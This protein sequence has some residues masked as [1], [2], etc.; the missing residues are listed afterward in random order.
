MGIT[1]PDKELYV[2]AHTDS[3][4]WLS[5]HG[6]PEEELT[7]AAR[8]HI[9]EL[10][11]D[12]L[13]T[14]R[15]VPLPKETRDALVD[16]FCAN[17]KMREY[18]KTCA[19]NEDCLVRVYLGGRKPKPKAYAGGGKFFGLRNFQLNLD[20]MVCLEDPHNGQG[21]LDL[22]DVLEL[23]KQMGITLAVMHWD[24][25]AHTDAIDV[26][27]VLG[28][29]RERVEATD[30]DVKEGDNAVGDL[31]GQVSSMGTGRT[32]RSTQMW[33]LNF[34]QCRDV[35][36]E[37]EFMKLRI[38]AVKLN[39]PYFPKPLRETVVERAVWTIFVRAY[40]AASEKILRKSDDE[41]VCEYGTGLG[42]QKHIF[43]LPEEF[44]L[45][46]IELERER[47]KRSEAA[48]RE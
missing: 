10:P 45:G 35:Y 9:T 3:Q 23:A 4:K 5:G 6:H 22:E 15:I 47:R 31:Q 44:I 43:N 18:I 7:A 14:E 16:V 19:A 21:V 12:V 33:V 36:S 40:L 13:V 25:D 42:L 29:S 24:R 37:K 34:N 2:A 28:S 26:E 48:G 1:V 38:E 46:V 41:L 32:V 39:D 17:A 11:T 27:F 30:G 20:Q 8:P